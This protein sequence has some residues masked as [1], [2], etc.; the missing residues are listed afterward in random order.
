M[1]AAMKVSGASQYLMEVN[2]RRFPVENMV[3]ASKKYEVIRDRSGLGG[4][5]LSDGVVRD[6]EGKV[7][8]RVSYNAKVW[9]T[10]EWPK[11]QC[12]YNPYIKD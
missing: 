7:I 12:V 6:G 8:A 5:Q 3:D 1:A 4:S 10:E 9:T 2:G 11:C